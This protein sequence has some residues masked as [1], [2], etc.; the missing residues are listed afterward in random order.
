MKDFDPVKYEKDCMAELQ[1]MSCGEI[2][3]NN[4]RFNY[5]WELK[6]KL[7]EKGKY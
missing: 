6:C 4:K 5:L 1:R 7:E 2:P 3:M